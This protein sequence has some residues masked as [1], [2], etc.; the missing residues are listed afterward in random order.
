MLTNY[1][2]I[3]FDLGGVLL[4]L[5][6]DLC[7]S[8]LEALGLSDAASLLD[9]YEQSGDFL[10]LEEG[11]MWGAEFLD[12]QRAKCSGTTVTNMQ[13]NEAVNSFINGL[14]VERLKA[15]RELKAAGKRLFTLSNT[16]PLMFPTRISNLFRAE[17][18]EIDDYF[19]G[20]ILSY[21]EQVCKPAPEIYQRL[22]RRYRLDPERTLFLDDSAKNCE[23]AEQEGIRSVLIPEGAEFMDILQ[24]ID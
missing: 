13:I 19:D 1:D 21:R 14:P 17:G 9:L 2:N 16:N 12:R 4:T 15:L 22:L 10:A 6:R 11:R 5:D 3:V 20:H 8:N 24:F 7:V 23:A 18:L